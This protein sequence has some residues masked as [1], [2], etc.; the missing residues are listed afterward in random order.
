[1][2]NAPISTQ[3]A[4]LHLADIELCK[5]KL[6]LASK[7]VTTG[8]KDLE[9]SLSQVAKHQIE[10]TYG[11]GKSKAIGGEDIHTQLS[12]EFPEGKPIGGGKTVEHEEICFRREEWSDE[13]CFEYGK[14][15]KYGH[16][17]VAVTLENF[18][19][20]TEANAAAW[21]RRR[22]MHG[23]LWV[24]L[25]HTETDEGGRRGYIVLV[26][27]EKDEGSLATVENGIGCVVFC[28]GDCYHGELKDS[29]MYGKGKYTCGPGATAMFEGECDQRQDIVN[30]L[31]YDGVWDDDQFRKGKITYTDGSVFE[32]GLKDNLRSQGQYYFANGCVYDGLW[33][34]DTFHK[35]KMTYTDGTTY[36]GE[37]RDCKFN[38]KGKCT[39]ANGIVKDGMWENNEYKPLEIVIRLGRGKLICTLGR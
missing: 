15:T 7:A 30:G 13:A 25:E 17:I 8:D 39:Y 36:E 32:G 10:I 3:N 34:Y 33:K 20:W 29:K 6:F 11:K 22:E 31:I 21:R 37:W 26:D 5:G 1:M 19:V 12:E 9:R 23:R 35:G 16:L 2:G 4:D 27:T 38:G 18:M 28:C 24:Y 14:H